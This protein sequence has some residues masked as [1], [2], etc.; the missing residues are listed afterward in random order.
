MDIRRRRHPVIK[1]CPLGGAGACAM[2]RDRAAAAGT[3][4]V[5]IRNKF[6]RACLNKNGRNWRRRDDEMRRSRMGRHIVAAAAVCSDHVA[7]IRR[8]DDVETRCPRVDGRQ[9][10]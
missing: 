1:V 2:T 10:S 7:M 9:A 8:P 3:R 5:V 6:R 4:R